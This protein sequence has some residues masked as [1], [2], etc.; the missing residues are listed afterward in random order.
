M[1]AIAGAALLVA[2]IS[3]EPTTYYFS[4]EHGDDAA[5]GLS[6]A[7]PWRTLAKSVILTIHP[8]RISRVSLNAG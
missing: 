7:S 8:M 5:T 3:T 4:S 6:P 2:A 1:S